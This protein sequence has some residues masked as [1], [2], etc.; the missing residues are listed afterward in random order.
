[1]NAAMSLRNTVLGVALALSAL[2]VLAGRAAAETRTVQGEQLVL[3]DTGSSHIDTDPSLSGS[4]R[5]S[6]SG[7]LSCLSIVPGQA[8]AISTAGCDD[9]LGSLRITVS[10]NTAVTLT[11]SGDGSARISDLR[12][13]LTVTLTN[14]YD[15]KTGHVGALALT[16]HSS[17]DSV[18]GAVDGPT[19]L[20]MTGSGDVSLS[21]AN[22]PVSVQRRGSG[23]LV[24]GTIEAP[25]LRID[26]QGSGDTLIGGGDIDR[27]MVSMAGSGDLAIAAQVAG[28]EVSAAGG[29]DVK[30]GVVTG[31]LRR[32]A[33]GGSDI[34][35]GGAAIVTDV[36]AR[37]ARAVGDS[38]GGS[39]RGITIT[40]S[41]SYWFGHIVTLALVCV[42]LFF[43]WR[44]VQRSRLGGSRAQSSG[45][46]HPGV[47]AVCE[48]MTRLEQRLGR[49]EGYV[50]TREFDLNRKFRDLGKT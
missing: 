34:S 5:V 7:S 41:S 43:G 46:L 45:P 24:I 44:I 19:S 35:V 26:S 21:R 14:S 38:S 47:Q 33:A 3:T 17:G 12:G 30:L 10:P 27:L 20:E 8:A 25:A 29:G 15:I 39:H 2:A 32:S 50:T 42:M 23:D 9:D 1:M 18:I 13:P 48:T 49:I 40:H 4:I 28:G 31:T 37:V 36:M 22:G 11:G 6:A 16:S